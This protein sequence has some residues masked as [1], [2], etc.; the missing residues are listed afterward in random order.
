M[1]PEVQAL[2]DEF[3]RTTQGQAAPEID[4]AYAATEGEGDGSLAYWRRVH[5][6]FFSKEC[7]SIGRDPSEEM[8]VVC[9]IFR[10]VHPPAATRGG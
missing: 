2:W 7:V 4:E 8:P 5:W 9:E 10:V 1:K 6:D 3:R